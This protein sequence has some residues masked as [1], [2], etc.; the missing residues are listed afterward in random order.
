MKTYLLPFIL[1]SFFPFAF[2][3]AQTL[4]QTIRGQVLDRDSRQPLIGVAAFVQEVTPTIGQY[5]DEKGYFRLENV[6]VGKRSL[7]FRYLGYRELVFPNVEVTSAKEVVLTIELE[8]QVTS[9]EAVVITSAKAKNKAINELSTVSSRQFS[10]E[11]TGRYAGSRGMWRAW[12]PTL[13]VYPAAMMRETIL[14]SEEIL[15]TD[16]SGGLKG[17]TSL[18]RTT[19]PASE[20]ME[21]RLASSIT[22][23]SAIL[24]L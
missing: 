1:L 24:T 8:E 2:L 3:S 15:P 22:M 6:P 20:P 17:S 7:A 4:T 11:E 9:T 19:F 14:S 12:P 5:T 13:P 23:S 18:A 21:G 16:C 10:T